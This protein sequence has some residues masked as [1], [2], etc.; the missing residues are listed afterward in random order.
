MLL[1]KDLP[2]LIFMD[3]SWFRSM[4]QWIVKGIA[5]FSVDVRGQCGETGNSLGSQHGI[6]KGWVT[7]GILDVDRCYYKTIAV[8]ALRAV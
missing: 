7:E 3:Y 6:V 5:V 1:M 8:D 2:E 4:K